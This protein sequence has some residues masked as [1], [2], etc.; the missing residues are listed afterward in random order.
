MN[1]VSLQLQ[2]YRA[3]K[4]QSSNAVEADP[5]ILARHPEKTDYF[6]RLMQRWQDT[7]R[8]HMPFVEK[9][10]AEMGE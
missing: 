2:Q 3:L 5:A 7:Y 9:V 8:E 10:P 6:H 4:A 1:N